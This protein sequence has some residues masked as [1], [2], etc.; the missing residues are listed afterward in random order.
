MIN[1][2]LKEETDIVSAARKNLSETWKKNTKKDQNFYF[3]KN[4]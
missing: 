1:F 2:I 4:R 3:H